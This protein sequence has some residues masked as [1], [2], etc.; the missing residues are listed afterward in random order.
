MN[1]QAARQL[2][3]DKQY[4]GSIDLYQ[5]LIQAEPA[6]AIL[7]IELSSAL[8]AVGQVDEALVVAKQGCKY[9]SPE[10]MVHCENQLAQIFLLQ[11]RYDLAEE[12][13]HQVI[14]SSPEFLEAYIGISSVY[15]R[16]GYATKACSILEHCES[17]GGHV[18]RWAHNYSQALFESRKA[19]KA[20]KQ[21]LLFTDRYGLDPVLATNAWMFNS[22]VEALDRSIALR[23]TN[24]VKGSI[25]NKVF[26]A[27]SGVEINRNHC[28][29]VGF[30]SSDFWFHPVGQFFASFI[31]ELR[32]Q[33]VE[34]H[35]FSNGSVEDEWT[36]RIRDSVTSFISVRD[37]T[38]KEAAKQIEEQELDVLIDLSG[39]TAGNRFDIFALRPCAVQATYLG[40][41]D[42]THLPFIDYVLTDERHVPHSAQHL[43]SEKIAYIEDL[44]FCFSEPIHSPRLASPPVISNGYLTFGSFANPAK[45]S[46]ACL[47]FWCSA[48]VAIPNSRLRLQHKQWVDLLLQKE[49]LDEMSNHGVSVGRIEFHGCVKYDEYM[50]A[51]S[52]IDLVLDTLPFTGG[53]T[54]CEALWAGVPVLTV[55][56]G[57]ASSRQSAAIL[58]SLG[59]DGF[60]ASSVQQGLEVLK[61]IASNVSA[62]V[63]FKEEVRGRIS[64]SVLGDPTRFAKNF[65]DA[66]EKIVSSSHRK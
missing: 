51:Y 45:I 46:D 66:I 33:D 53:T 64:K 40:F 28:L 4:M 29:R 48:L 3:H 31:N 23:L 24:L 54:T 27:K 41:P 30:I 8:I 63:R 52:R 62:L 14:R 12:K 20:I 16:T 6:N 60:V 42:S 26:P 43:Y 39:P 25:H 44:R 65:K 17:I 15:L 57:A 7:Y 50:E 35:L 5:R 61:D 21:I 9:A 47:K 22:Y 11:K 19:E 38:A 58:R 13:F 2:F 1:V 49:V 59:F 56:G 34:I 32:S 10:F 36:R 37:L 55:E 18:Q